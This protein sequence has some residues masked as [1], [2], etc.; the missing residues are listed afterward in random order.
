MVD[1]LHF[2][3]AVRRNDQEA[4]ECKVASQKFEHAER[5][6]VRP[7]QVV[8]NHHDWLKLG[9][10]QESARN[11]VTHLEAGIQARQGGRRSAKQRGERVAA[12]VLNSRPAI[13]N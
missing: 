1:K 8:Q 10:F 2:D 5:G 7:M 12:N 13:W 9:D 6:S 3:V 4:L 11:R